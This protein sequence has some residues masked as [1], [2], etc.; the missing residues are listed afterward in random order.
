MSRIA[1]AI[2]VAV[3]LLFFVGATACTAPDSGARIEIGARAPDFTLP[4]LDGGELDSA[5]ITGT[6]TILSFWATWCR[7]CWKEIPV[8]QQLDSSGTVQVVSIALDEAG[9]QIVRPFVERHDMRYTVLL[10]DQ[11]TFER[12]GGFTIPYTLVLDADGIVVDLY[13]GPVTHEALSADL[14]D[15]ENPS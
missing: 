8:L 13:R 14:A 2:S 11:N 12:F 4:L 9:E 1:S 6:P 7:P 10:G 5:S 15:L 3:T